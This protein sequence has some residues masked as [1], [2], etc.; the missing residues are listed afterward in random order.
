MIDI[1]AA[2]IGYDGT[3]EM[4]E[5]NEPRI[6]SEIE[7]IKNTILYILFTKP[8]QYPSLPSIGLDIESKLYSFYD[9]INTEDLKEKLI[10]QCNAL[11]AYINSGMVD[12]RKQKYRN[13]PSLLI[14]IEGTETYPEG[15]MKDSYN[16]SDRY[17]IGITFDQLN[18]MIYNIS[19]EK[20]VV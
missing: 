20:G 16:G 11:G 15:Y 19:S 7:V 17:L 18:K 10:N 12:I 14:H 5:F 1:T 2:R 3:F 8:G 4:N 6:R 9:E 13:K